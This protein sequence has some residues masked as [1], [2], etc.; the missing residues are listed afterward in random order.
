[1]SPVRFFLYFGSGMG[2]NCASLKGAL[3]IAHLR[4]TWEMRMVY[5][6]ARLCLRCSSRRVPVPGSRAARPG[7]ILDQVAD[8]VVGVKRNVNHGICGQVVDCHEIFWPPALLKTALPMFRFRGRRARDLPE[9]RMN[10]ALSAE[11][12]LSMVLMRIE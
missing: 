3:L 2:I 9:K 1:M 11:C 10:W 6:P 5:V 7:D 4:V 12:R 8:G